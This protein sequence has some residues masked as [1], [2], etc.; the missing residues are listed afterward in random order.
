V[1]D[2]IGAECG[3]TR[4]MLQ[5]GTA[6][7]NPFFEQWVVKP[8]EIHRRMKTQYGDAWLLLQQVYE[9]DRNFKNG[10]QAKLTL[11]TEVGLTLHLQQRQ[12]STLNE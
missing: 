11:I 7:C 6:F 5:R 1:F 3:F 9:W 4:D 2:V 12:R 10:C 8:I